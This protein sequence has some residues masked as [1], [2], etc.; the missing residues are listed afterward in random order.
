MRRTSPA[1]AAR[2]VALAVLLL[3]TALAAAPEDDYD[4]GV[5]LYKKARWEQAAETFRGFLAANPDHPRAAN[6][7]LYRGLALVNAEDYAAARDVLR[8][9]VRRYPENKSLPDALYRIGEAD[10]FLGDFKAAD[11]DLIAFVSRFPDHPLTEWA[12]PYLG[13]AR[14]RLDKPEAAAAAFK[15]SLD[16]HPNG[17]LATE[18]KFGL[19]RSEEALNRP[20]AAAAIYGELAKGDGSR[21]ASSHLRLGSLAF[22]RGRYADAVAAFADLVRRFPKSDLVPTARL[23]AGFALYREEKYPAALAELE[24]AAATPAQA[25]T[26]THWIGMTRVALGDY[27]AAAAAFKTVAD[28]F[29]DSP[30]A[31]D[32]L[33]HWADAALRNRQFDEAARLFVRTVDADP[34]GPRAA[35]ALHL[36]GESALLAGKLDEAKK[37][38]ELFGQDYGGSAF[39]S[40]NRLLGGRILAAE[41]ERP[42]VPQDRR[43]ELER[44]A[45]AEYAAVSAVAPKDA[46]TAQASLFAARLRSRRGENAEA[47]AALAPIL[48]DAAR[49]KTD[50]VRL[51][52]LLI[53]A[54]VRLAE[55]KPEEAI[56]AA[57]ASLD[58]A[59]GGRQADAALAA[60]AAAQLAAGHPEEAKADWT[61]LQDRFPK[62]DLI[63]PA[64]RSLAERAYDRQE[65]PLSAE[66]F[67]ALAARTAG[68][69]EQ[70]AALAG[71]GWS[72]SRAGEFDAAA[73]AFGEVLDRGGDLPKLGPEAGYMRG[74]SLQDAGKLDAAAAAY[75]AAFER[76]APAE[77]AAAG[78]EADGPLRNVYLAGL[79]RARVLRLQGK[80][81]DADAAYAAVV[82][83]FPQPRNLD[84]LLDEW[85]LLHYEAEDYAKADVLFRRLIAERPES[86]FADDA[87][88]SLAESD[89]FAGRL[90]P[91]AESFRKLA[92]D[93]KA[94][95]RVRERSLSLL[96]GLAAERRDWKEATALATTFLDRFPES[97]ERPIVQFQLGEAELQSGRPDDAVKTLSQV[98]AL[99]D[100]AAVKSQPWFPRTYVLLAEAAFQQKDYA[101]AEA[102]VAKVKAVS[103]PPEY[104][105]LADEV[106]GRALKNQRKFDEARA[107]FGRV[108]DDA[109]AR[110]TETAA[111][112]QYEI[113]QTHFLQE[114][115]QE[116]Q[117]AAFKVYTLYAFPQWQAPA[118]YMAGL[119]DETLG[120]PEKAAAAFGDV[121]K[122]FPE[123]EYAALAKQK[124]AKTGPAG[125]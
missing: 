85:A 26:A 24:P 15:T 81:A 68:T 94:D 36:A 76:F 77:P 70:A 14:L 3:P 35:E 86:E 41:A 48:D 6:A 96:V 99:A 34:K 2:A 101:A 55:G 13:D 29:P 33:F 93:A 125:R 75:R 84:A 19:A 60:R 112:A 74:K 95:A 109:N 69:P 61:A 62:S 107:A 110:R 102:N 23:N 5:G 65:W 115:W 43:D 20:D 119:C 103:P 44:Q 91:A 38:S 51:D 72:R 1:D 21:A 27:A 9:F 104:A 97:R 71:L 42:D 12:W 66:F 40:R 54:R 90:D 121:V 89:L 64:T 4:L 16:K 28:K 106:L 83:K 116:A 10:Y 98:A 53:A 49:E 92:D 47:M 46:T 7:R 87:A 45:L 113:A 58:A 82:A 31:I 79:Q 123:S 117:T 25:A 18:A 50:P 32:S 57:T 59:P 37:L 111:R 80:T 73:T 88:L 39:A 63:V 124:L 108:L 22:D 120:R 30:V 114:N 78:A 122:E 118:L 56:Q 17:K 105:Y 52:A 100:D 11:A 67:T 8:E